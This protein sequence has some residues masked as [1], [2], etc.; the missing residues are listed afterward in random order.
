M[1]KSSTSSIRCSLNILRSELASMSKSLFSVFRKS[2]S[3][4]LWVNLMV[5]SWVLVFTTHK[6]NV[7]TH[8]YHSVHGEG[9]GLC[10]GGGCL[11][12]GSL[13]RG[14]CL[15]VSVQGSLSGGLCSGGQGDPH[16]IICRQYA[17]DWNSF[18]YWEMSIIKALTHNSLI[19][20]WAD[21]SIRRQFC[22]WLLLCTLAWSEHC[23]YAL[24]LK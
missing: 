12:R 20:Y 9:K 2:E 11:S 1:Y 15:G 5:G 16:M 24:I 14:L 10:P 6:G 19:L 4:F 8:V 7:F 23:E 13:S 17:S 18:L 21:S 22:H 3:G